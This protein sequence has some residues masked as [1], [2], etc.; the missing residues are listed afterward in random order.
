MGTSLGRKVAR[1]KVV[2]KPSTVSLL[3]NMFIEQL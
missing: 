1:N 3:I 2:S